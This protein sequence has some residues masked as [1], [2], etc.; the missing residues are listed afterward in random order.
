MLKSIIL[1]GGKGTRLRP[2]TN[3]VNKHLLPVFSR[4]MVYYPID[5]LVRSGVKDIMII[6]GDEH[7]GGF[8]SLLKDGKEFGADF[9]YKVQ[10][11][12][13]GIAGAL[14]LASKWANNEPVAAILG[15]NVYNDDFSKEIAV[16]DNKRQGAHIFLKTVVD[17]TRFGVPTIDED[18]KIVN[19]IEKPKIPDSKFAVTGLYLFDQKVWDILPTLTPSARGELEITDVLNEYLKLGE[20]EYSVV[21]GFWSDAGTPESLND[22]SN[23][24]RGLYE[25][26]RN[27]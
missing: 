9:T 15:D 18:G 12:S 16:M 11:E 24:V 27:K 20:L 25:K 14:S 26:T 2:M 19:I 13:N 23:F 17:P 5:T 4:P 22:A 3:V 21:G 7:V 10:T 6:S 8:M 1:C